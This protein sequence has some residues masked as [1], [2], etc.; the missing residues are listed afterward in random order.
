MSFAL[1]SLLLCAPNTKRTCAPPRAKKEQCVKYPYV[2]TYGSPK[3]KYV[4]VN[5]FDI[6]CSHCVEFYHNVFPT[7]KKKFCDTGKVLFVFRPYPIHQETLIFMSCCTALNKGQKQALFETLMEMDEPVTTDTI[8]ECMSVLKIPSS[9]LLSKP[10][11]CVLQDALV[12]TEKYSFE[13][14]PVMFLN[15]KLLTDNQQDNVLEFLEKK[16]I[17]RSA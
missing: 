6:G 12:L 1:F 17:N 9:N 7:L 5:Y 3:A 8:S 2:V 14:L 11:A 15:E 4:L 10:T 13:S 16:T